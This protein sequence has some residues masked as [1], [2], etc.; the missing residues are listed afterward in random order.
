[1][2]KNNNSKNKINMKN[3]IVYYL[4]ILL[5]IPLLIWLSK[6]NNSDWF[7]ILLLVYALPYRTLIDGMRLIS[8]KLMGWNEIWKLFIPDQKIEYTRELYF[9]K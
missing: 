6:T 4:A 1:M 7:T 8:K 9:K 3:I 5:P 2:H